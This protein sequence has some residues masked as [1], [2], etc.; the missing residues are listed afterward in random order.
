LWAIADVRGSG[1][2]DPADQGIV[3]YWPCTACWRGFHAW[4]GIHANKLVLEAAFLGLFDAD[5]G[6]PDANVPELT[7]ETAPALFGKQPVALQGFM[8][9][10]YFGLDAAVAFTG[11]L[12]VCRGF[13]YWAGYGR[14]WGSEYCVG[15][16][17]DAGLLTTVYHLTA[18]AAKARAQPTRALGAASFDEEVARKMDVSTR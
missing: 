1:Y 14:P 9:A 7:V 2:F 18:A 17:F 4:Y 5:R 11:T 16:A 13:E 3:V 10:P 12:L 6:P 8:G 15:F